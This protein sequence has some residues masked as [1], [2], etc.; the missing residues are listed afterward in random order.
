M[1]VEIQSMPQIQILFNLVASLDRDVLSCVSV[2]KV[3]N[4]SDNV[5]TFVTDDVVPQNI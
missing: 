3:C 5:A 4:G 1:Q 2:S